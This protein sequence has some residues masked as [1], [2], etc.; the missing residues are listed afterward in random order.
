[1]QSSKLKISVKLSRSLFLALTAA[2]LAACSAASDVDLENRSIVVEQT[3]EPAANAAIPPSMAGLVRDSGPTYVTLT[4]SEIDTQGS[5]GKDQR[6]KIAITSGSGFLV[7]KSGYVM[8]AAH[9]A[10]AKNYTVSARAA[11]GRVYTGSVV[12]VLPSNDMALIKLRGYSGR[13]VTPTANNCLARGA[14]VFS[15]GKP[16]AEGDTARMGQIES[17]HFG[18]PVQYGKFGYPDALVLHMNT[19]KGESGGPLFDGSGR[20]VGMVV[21]TLTDGEGQLL[22]L[23]HAVPATSLARFLCTHLACTGNWQTLARQSTDDCPE[24]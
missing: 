12:D 15:L 17:M 19:K 13:E 9:V 20:L 16:H 23:S 6:N 4:V 11:N 8:T 14:A 21:S 5:L 24:I 10:V 7:D 2:S 22:N 3:A 1:M 18:R